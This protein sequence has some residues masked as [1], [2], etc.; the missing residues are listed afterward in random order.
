MQEEQ[1]ERYE[2]EDEDTPWLCEEQLK[3]S[4]IDIQK[5]IKGGANT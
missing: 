3:R 2:L 4:G 1:K 5:I